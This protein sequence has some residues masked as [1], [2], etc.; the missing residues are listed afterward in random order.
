M[1]LPSKRLNR[2]SRIYRQLFFERKP[3]STIYLDVHTSVREMIFDDADLVTKR[4]PRRLGMEYDFKRKPSA[5]AMASVEV[6]SLG[7]T[8]E[9]V[10]F[11]TS[12]WASTEEFS[13][14]RKFWNA[15][16]KTTHKPIKT[17]EDFREYARFYDMM[18]SMPQDALPYLSRGPSGDLKR[19]QRDLCAAFKFGQA[20]LAAYQRMTAA[21]FAGLLNSTGLEANGVKTTRATVEN[22]KRLRFSLTPRRARNASL[23]SWRVFQSVPGVSARRGAGLSGYTRIVVASAVCG[24]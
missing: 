15:Q 21:E 16:W 22:G 17:A 2:I 23:R 11:N 3:D 1:S 19:L 4:L 5:V 24:L 10:A 20:G 8:F 6:P 14:A 9:H 7:R 12:P 13:K 18:V